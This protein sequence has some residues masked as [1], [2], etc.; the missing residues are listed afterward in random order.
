MAQTPRSLQYLDVG[1]QSLAHA[2]RLRAA[3]FSVLTDLKD[4]AFYEIIILLL[5]T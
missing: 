1:F 3:D 4:L 5:E 2:W